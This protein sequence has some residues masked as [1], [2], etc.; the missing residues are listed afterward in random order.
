MA[1]T[2]RMFA[3]M[4]VLVGVWVVAYWLYDP[5]PRITR[6]ALPPVPLAQVALSPLIPVAP[7][8]TPRLEAPTSFQSSPPSA[9][10]IRTDFLSAE[11]AP[12]PSP[13]AAPRTETRT[14]VVAPQFRETIVQKGDTSWQRI[15]RREL[16]DDKLWQ[17]VAR[18][19]PYL[20]SDRLKP[21]MTVVRIPLDPSNLQGKTVEVEVPVAG[22][23]APSAPPPS[24][25]IVAGKTY[26]VQDGDTL[27]SIARQFYGKGA[28]W[29]AIYNANRT[30]IKDS[31]RPPTGK[32]IV[33]P[34]QPAAAAT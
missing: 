33:I 12:Q 22:T 6:D 13:P 26:T 17:A 15:A 4:G 32:T 34:T 23:P 31:N 8:P 3:L 10:P 29:E 30:V 20:T 16:G 27:W 11:P 9:D 7:A 2:S 25:P 14:R 5:A 19:N 21:G 1:S 24:A 28:L 18:A